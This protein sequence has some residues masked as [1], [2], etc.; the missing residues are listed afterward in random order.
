MGNDVD[1]E[2]LHAYETDTAEALEPVVR[3][4]LTETVVAR[5]ERWVL[6]HGDARDARLPGERDLASRL[7]VSRIVVR[8]AIGRLAARGLIE[9]RPGVGSFIA[10]ARAASVIDPLEL[11][12]TRTGVALA[13]LLEVR[14]ALEPAAAA[15]AARSAGPEAIAAM[16]AVLA[17]TDA[18]VE[19][20]D[21]HDPTAL[22]AF[23]WA[24]VDF[25]QRLARASGNP[26]FDLVLAPLIDRL[27]DVRRDGARLPGAAAAAQSGH[28]AVLDAVRAGDAR[29]A[30]DAM[31]GHL[32]QVQGWLHHGRAAAESDDADADEA[33]GVDPDAP[34]RNAGANRTREEP[35]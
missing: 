10:P 27:L 2:A 4:S 30:E 13:H 12:L 19:N 18:I 8:E 28:R 23:A 25:H 34:D 9:V 35:T 22:E 7:G 1:L 21:P 31:R 15:A 26:V 6:A 33:T 17:R 16:S 32:E 29:G 24:D 5:L 20:L 11:Y 14:I 3:S